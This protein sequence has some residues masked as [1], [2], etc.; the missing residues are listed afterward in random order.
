MGAM[1]EMAGLLKAAR[2]TAKYA[3]AI[4]EVVEALRAIGDVISAI[5]EAGADGRWE[6]NEIVAV[7]KELEEAYKEVTEAIEAFSKA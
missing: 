3:T 6:P 1:Q 4:P 7:L 5:R 2:N